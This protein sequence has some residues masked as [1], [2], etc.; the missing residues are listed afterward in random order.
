MSN[1]FFTLF[2]LPV[3]FDI[4]KEAL[5]KS[6]L[7]LQKIH[8]PDQSADDAQ[9]TQMASLINHA[10]D[11][12]YY[13]DKRAA[14][15]LELAGISCHLDASINDWDFLDDMMEIRMNLD[16]ANDSNE[17]QAL[18]DTVN[19]KKT[20]HNTDFNHHYTTKNWQDAQNSA[21]KIQFLEKLAIDIQ[22]K[23]TESLS[24]H[25]NDDDLYV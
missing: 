25:D 24:T 23:L 9:P 5:K 12:L 14:H 10:Y 1:N 19:H 20:A 15:L 22:H 3:A 11:T 2:D 17:I 13:D 21:Q 18:L 6:L 7:S 16:D 8:H 4:D